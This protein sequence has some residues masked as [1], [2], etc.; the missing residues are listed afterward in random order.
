MERGERTLVSSCKRSQE[1]KG[2]AI[3][4]THAINFHVDKERLRL[5]RSYPV[6]IEYHPKAFIARVLI[7]T[8]TAARQYVV[9]FRLHYL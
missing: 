9:L 2:E 5:L 8:R 3:V 1:M 4:G 7:E 6:L